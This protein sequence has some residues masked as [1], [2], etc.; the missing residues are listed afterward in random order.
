MSAPLTQTVGGVTYQF[1]SWSDGGAANDNIN[2]PSSDTTYTAN[3]A[4]VSVTYLSDLP[5]TGKV[6]NGWG[7]MERD[8]SN[9]EKKAKDGHLIQLDG[10]TYLKG[11][12]IN[13]S[14]ERHVQS[15]RLPTPPSSPTSASTTKSD[16]NGSVTFQVWGDGVLLYDG[17][18]MTGELADANDR[19]ECGRREA[20]EACCDRRW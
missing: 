8:M 1:Q 20:I 2:F 10:V 13:A 11:L 19:C 17:S 9:G 5:T 3:Y 15:Q 4:P 6:K 12:G 14:F 16:R 18:K 7:S